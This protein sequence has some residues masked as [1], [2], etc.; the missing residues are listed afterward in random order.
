MNP[1]KAQRLRD[2]WG[3]KPCGHPGFVREYALGMQGDYICTQ[4]GREFLTDSP[5]HP[6]GG[7]REEKTPE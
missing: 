6:V 3:D 2:E 7:K 4:C 5:N 1:D